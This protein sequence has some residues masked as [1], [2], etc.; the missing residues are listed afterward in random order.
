MQF[1]S[2]KII[3][4]LNDYRQNKVKAKDTS[5]WARDDPSLDSHHADDLSLV[6]SIKWLKSII[7]LLSQNIPAVFVFMQNGSREFQL[8]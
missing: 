7:T 5:V 2:Y 6:A 3:R 4:L 8:R 1:T